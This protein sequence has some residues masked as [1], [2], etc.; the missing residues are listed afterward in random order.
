MEVATPPQSAKRYVRPQQ[1]I[2]GALVSCRSVRGV[3]T[4]DR[5]TGSDQVGRIDDIV[6]IAA[7]GILATRVPETAGR[8][9]G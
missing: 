9:H 6:G 5:R 7:N 4:A 3:I 1:P 8:R 2:D